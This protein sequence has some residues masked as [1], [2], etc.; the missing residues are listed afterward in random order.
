MR[1]GGLAERSGYQLGRARRPGSPPDR[2]YSSSSSCRWRG[3]SDVLGRLR[4]FLPISSSARTS[5]T[6]LV[7]SSDMQHVPIAHQRRFLARREAFSAGRS[8]SQE[9]RVRTGPSQE[10]PD[11]SNRLRSWSSGWPRPRGVG[12]AVGQAEEE[13]QAGGEVWDSSHAPSRSV[14]RA[15]LSICRSMRR[16]MIR[17]PPDPI[18]AAR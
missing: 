3:I 12:G 10:G 11:E 17:W 13:A 8:A 15:R 18:T 14:S 6:D 4:T 9:A 2:P 1:Q 16:V 7:V 5:L